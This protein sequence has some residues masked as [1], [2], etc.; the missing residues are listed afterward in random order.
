[1]TFQIWN[2]IVL[3]YFENVML[4]IVGPTYG[5]NQQTQ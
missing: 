4:Y 1:M 3:T 2:V 5:K